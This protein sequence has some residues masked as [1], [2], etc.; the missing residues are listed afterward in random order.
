MHAFDYLLL[1]IPTA[2]VATQFG[3]RRGFGPAKVKRWTFVI[4]KGGRLLEIIK[5]ETRMHR[6][7][8]RALEVLAGAL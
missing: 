7:A 6:H 5:S 4:A 3:V 1:S 8:D 2:A